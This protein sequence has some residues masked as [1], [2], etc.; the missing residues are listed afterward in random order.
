MENFSTKSSLTLSNFEKTKSLTS[1]RKKNQNIDIKLLSISEQ[2]FQKSSQNSNT[3]FYKN[4]HKDIFELCEKC[5][6]GYDK[7]EGI[8]LN[9]INNDFFSLQNINLKFLKEN[10]S[11]FD[12]K[13]YFASKIPN[14]ILCQI[15]KNLLN[16][17]TECY[18]CNKLFCRECLE[19]EI[20]KNKKCPCC[21]KF[22]DKNCLQNLDKE[23]NEIYSKFYLKCPFPFCKE[24]FRLDVLREHIK[25]CDFRNLNLNNNGKNNNNFNR[26]G[27]Y[28]FDNDPLLKHY[29]MEYFINKNNSDQ[30]FDLGYFVYNDSEHKERLDDYFEGNLEQ[31]KEDKKLFELRN[32]LRKGE[33]NCKQNSNQIFNLTKETNQIIKKMLKNYN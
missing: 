22:I 30:V 19:K 16:N 25:I 12:I 32:L 28:D 7:V 27:L 26:D 17:P 31:F 10:L 8:N 33:K 6:N 5:Y 29:L 11:K 18:K 2:P 13:N 23:I 1:N 15:C 14:E 4:F 24:K 3:I 20:D 21:K 9:D